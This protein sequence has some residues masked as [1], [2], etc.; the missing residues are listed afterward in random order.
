[1][2]RIFVCPSENADVVRRVARFAIAAY[3]NVPVYAAFHEWLGRGELL[4]PMWD[5]WKAGDRKAA[6]AAIP[7]E[8][9]DDLIVHGSPADVPGAHPAVLRQRRDDE[10]ARHHAARSRAVTLGRGPLAGPDGGV[11][12]SCLTAGEQAAELG[13]VLK[14]P[15]ASRLVE[16]E[17]QRD[18]RRGLVRRLG[19]GQQRELLRGLV[20]GHATI[21]FRGV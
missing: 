4:R 20:L 9:V 18:V 2:A 5:A 10:F 1:M 6:L 12:A 14:A 7:D 16:A 13:D 17:L 15:A 11:E 8:V 21:L 3:M 19:R